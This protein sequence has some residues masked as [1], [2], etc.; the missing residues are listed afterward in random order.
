MFTA[1]KI[2][3][4]TTKWDKPGEGSLEKFIEISF[5][6]LFLEIPRKLLRGEFKSQNLGANTLKTSKLDNQFRGKDLPQNKIL[7]SKIEKRLFI[8]M[9]FNSS[10]EPG[11]PK[12]SS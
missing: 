11:N 3:N 4:L 5:S 12:K 6:K 1:I 8:I 2:N 9:K 10:S 7:G